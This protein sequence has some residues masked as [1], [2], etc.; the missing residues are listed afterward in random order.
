MSVTTEQPVT[1]GDPTA[2]RTVLLVDDHPIFRHGLTELLDRQPGLVVCGHADS[3][4]GALE[5]M[6]RLKPDVA[7]IDISLRGQTGSSSL[8]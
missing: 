2:K 8:S 5:Q 3:A 1:P 7:L 6:R 4:P